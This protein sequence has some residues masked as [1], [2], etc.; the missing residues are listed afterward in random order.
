MTI[1]RTLF[2]FALLGAVVA[3]LAACA[4]RTPSY[5]GAEG[6][7]ERK[8]VLAPIDAVTLVVRQSVPA[9]YA[10]DVESGLPSGCARFDRIEVKREGTNVDLTVWNTV[11]ADATAMCTMIYG[12]ARNTAELGGDFAAGQLYTVRVNGEAKLTFTARQA[13]R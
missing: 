12:T 4:G 6:S 3:S 7:V 1:L 13:G 5:D 2:G 8:R 11:P 9:G 10:V